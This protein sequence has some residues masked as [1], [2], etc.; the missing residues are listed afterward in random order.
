MSDRPSAAEPAFDPEL[1]QRVYDELQFRHDELLRADDARQWTRELSTGQRWA[2][3][4]LL[5]AL[6]AAPALAVFWV[7]AVFFVP[8]TI[9]AG[10]LLVMLV[11]GAFGHN[12]IVGFFVLAASTALVSAVVW[13]GPAATV[14]TISAGVWL[15]GTFFGARYALRDAG[16]RIPHVYRDQYVVPADLHP[17]E[18]G[19][20]ARVQVVV[21]LTESAREILGGEFDATRALRTLHAQEWTLAQLF[22]RRSHLARDLERRE[23]EAVSDAVQRSLDPQ[24]SSLQRVRAEAEER[25]A[26]I[27]SYGRT[28]A[29][30]LVKQREWEQ[31]CENTARD[32]AYGDL[33]FETGSAP[34]QQGEGVP[35]DNALRAVRENRDESVRQALDEVR[36]LSESQD[37][38]DR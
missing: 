22:L 18:R 2:E 29:D 34:E 19:M 10:I 14:Y 17:V 7:A 21:D 5:S 37:M 9:I 32:D 38:L 11:F 30:A 16:E 4:L 1:P 15:T 24:R 25:V 8:L 20:L 12:P 33:L 36:W 13:L 31:V 27:E 6:S 28:V 23:R 26:R 3:A 35:E